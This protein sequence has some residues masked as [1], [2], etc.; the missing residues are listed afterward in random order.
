MIKNSSYLYQGSAWIIFPLV[1]SSSSLSAALLLKLKKEVLGFT[2]LMAKHY[3]TG[4]AQ[5]SLLLLSKGCACELYWIKS[6]F[7]RPATDEK[8]APDPKFACPSADT[9]LHN[10][11][12]V[13]A[14]SRR[15][16]FC[17]EQ[18]MSRSSGYCIRPSK[19]CS[20]TGMISVFL[21]IASSTYYLT[22][23]FL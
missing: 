15:R 11:F 12:V 5:I 14:K 21:P 17:S 10:G 13:A 3:S 7:Q 16:R 9:D 2:T 20:S 4:E 8:A 22:L 1:P 6:V 23:V 18:M 19:N